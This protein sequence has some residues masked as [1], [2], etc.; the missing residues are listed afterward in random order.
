VLG[1]TQ[2]TRVSTVKEMLSG[3]R[4]KEIGVKRIKDAI[5]KGMVVE[6]SVWDPMNGATNNVGKGEASVT[7]PR[8]FETETAHGVV[9][10][11]QALNQVN[12]GRL[13]SSTRAIVG[14]HVR[15][16]ARDSRRVA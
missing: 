8:V 3:F 1:F 11:G 12:K 13:S 4:V 10:I 7:C 9:S 15:F 16:A 2:A 14:R 5:V 6:I